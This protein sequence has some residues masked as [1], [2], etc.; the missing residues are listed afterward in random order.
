MR[1]RIG[2]GRGGRFAERVALARALWDS[3]VHEGRMAAAR[4]LTQARIKTG[5][6]LVWE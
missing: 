6:V 4:L 1:W 2:G 3:D 5:E